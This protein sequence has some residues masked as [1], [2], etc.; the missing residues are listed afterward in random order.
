MRWRWHEEERG[1]YRKKANSDSKKLQW[2]RHQ[3]VVATAMIVSPRSKIWS[4]WLVKMR[5]TKRGIRR[6]K[7]E[8]KKQDIYDSLKKI[9]TTKMATTATNNKQQHR[10]IVN[11][12]NTTILIK[13]IY[14]TNSNYLIF[15]FKVFLALL[16]WS[17][18][19][20]CWS[21]WSILLYSTSVSY[22]SATVEALWRFILNQNDEEIILLLVPSNFSNS[23]KKAPWIR[24]IFCHCYRLREKIRQQK[25]Q[26]DTIISNTLSSLGDLYGVYLTLFTSSGIQTVKNL[27]A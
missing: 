16:V 18:L 10:W 14:C 6:G 2:L 4:V 23:G 1:T 5:R 17:L 13:L 20:C 24:K 9:A 22:P 25:H 12:S 27:E 11:K 8:K 3:P 7:R 21:F 26:P 19:A 15:N